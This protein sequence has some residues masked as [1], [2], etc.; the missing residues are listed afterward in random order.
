MTEQELIKWGEVQYLTGRLDELVYK[1]VPNVLDLHGSRKLDVR[2]QKYLDKLKAV[3]QIAYLSYVTH[4]INRH[5]DKVRGQKKMDELF[6]SIIAAVED[7][8]L[9][10]RIRDQKSKYSLE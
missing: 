3:D 5:H 1:A 4:R 2:V 10:Q 7:P 6:E 8:A 9:V